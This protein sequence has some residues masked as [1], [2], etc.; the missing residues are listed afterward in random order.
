MSPSAPKISRLPIRRM[1]RGATCLVQFH[2][3]RSF[4]TGWETF[5]KPDSAKP[6]ASKIWTIQSAR[7]MASS[8]SDEKTVGMYHSPGWRAAT[9]RTAFLWKKGSQAHRLAFG[10]D[11][12]LRGSDAAVPAA[13]SPRT[14]P[15]NSVT[16]RGGG[17]GS[18]SPQIHH[19]QLYVPHTLRLT[20]IQ[21]TSTILPRVWRFSTSR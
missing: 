6:R 11:V 14:S 17:H 1:T 10:E 13:G 3:A 12:E 9:S 5:P 8:P 4:A 2:L 16:P 20:G 21:G 19:P 7:V 15:P 18:P